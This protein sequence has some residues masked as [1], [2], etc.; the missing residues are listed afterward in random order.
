MKIPFRQIATAIPLALLVACQQA[1]VPT[2][3]KQAA[4]SAPAKL[5]DL[6]INL[7]SPDMAVKTWWRYKDFVA[8]FNQKECE[9]VWRNPT[10]PIQ[11]VPKIASGDVLRAI[12][13][14]ACTLESFARE[15]E[16][17]KIES[18]TRAVVFARIKNIT[19]VPSGAEPTELDKKWRAGGFKYKYVVEKTADGWKVTQ[20]FG[21]LG[22]S[23]DWQKAYQPADKPDYP[24]FV[25]RQ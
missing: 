5:A 22:D 24:S 3:S 18:E 7:T 6:E 21:A 11:Y 19:P 13:E 1:A 4:T 14:Q 15:I 12:K 23:P 20:A 10:D 9:A 25:G 8:A 16:E 17:V 2:E